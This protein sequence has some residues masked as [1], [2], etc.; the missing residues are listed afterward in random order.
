MQ[1]GKKEKKRRKV[2]RDC[3]WH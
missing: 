1:A 3:N 2:T